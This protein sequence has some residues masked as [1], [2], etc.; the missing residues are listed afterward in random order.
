VGQ[1]GGRLLLAGM[2]VDPGLAELLQLVLHFRVVRRVE[3]V[4]D[5]ILLRGRL[6]L[7]EIV[8]RKDERIFL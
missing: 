6:A 1:H 2:A 3:E 4:D 8:L 7:A 5:V